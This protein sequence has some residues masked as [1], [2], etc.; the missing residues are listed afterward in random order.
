MKVIISM[1]GLSSRFSDVGYTIP[2]F[3]IDI[4]GRKVI[5]HIIKLYPSDSDFLFIINDKHAEDTNIVQLLEDSVD[6][7]DIVVIPRHKK[8]PVFSIRNFEDYIND[9][10]QVVINYCDFSMYWD[11]NDFERLER[12]NHLLMIRCLSLLRLELIISRKDHM[13]RS[14]LRN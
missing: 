13:L 9:D 3:M 4:D 12:R 8:G 11:Y 7:K 6:K 14:I 1:S 10:E 2:K 5:E